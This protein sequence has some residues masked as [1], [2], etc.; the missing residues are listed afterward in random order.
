[1]KDTLQK[2]HNYR[3]SFIESLIQKFKLT[4]I[5][6]SINKGV[7]HLDYISESIKLYGYTSKDFKKDKNF[8]KTIFFQEDYS[9]LMDRYRNAIK[10]QE[11][12]FQSE[13]RIW[14][15]DRKLF[16][17]R[18]LTYLDYNSKGELIR[19]ESIWMDITKE[20]IKQFEIEDLTRMNQNILE[21]MNDAIAITNSDN[22]FTYVNPAFL[23][24][25][26][27][28]NKCFINKNLLT[29]IT[30]EYRNQL[31]TF[32]KQEGKIIKKS[33]ETKI[34]TS[35]NIELDADVSLQKLYNRNGDYLGVLMVI[36]DI[37]ELKKAEND[38]LRTQTRYWSLF[39]SANEAFFV[40]KDDKIEE[41]NKKAEELFQYD[42][43]K[44]IGMYFADLSN[45]EGI[46]DDIFRRKF[47]QIFKNLKY[48]EE[49]EFQYTY[50]K[51]SGKTFEAN[52]KLSHIQNLDESYIFAI[53]DDNSFQRNLQI[54]LAEERNL[55]QT[56]LSN[57]QEAL[58]S[59]NAE[60]KILLFNRMAEKLTGW[61]VKDA[62]G[63]NLNEVL[64]CFHF[65][66]SIL[67][68]NLFN[69]IQEKLIGSKS[70]FYEDRMIILT[71]SNFIRKVS[72]HCSIMTQYKK[73][74]Q[75]FVIVFRDI[76]IEEKIR[77][78]A[79]KSQKMES[80][81]LLAGGI[82]HDFNN[83]L[84]SILGN[85]SIAKL[86]IGSKN[87]EM[88]QLLEETEN[89]IHRA[90]RLTKQLLTFSKGGAPIK[91]ITSL[92]EVIEEN[93]KFALRG[94]KIKLF[95]QIAPDLWNVEV[96]EGQ[97]G[98]CIHNILINALQA[99]PDGGNIIVEARNIKE[100]EK[101]P[102][103]PANQKFIVISIM[104]Q[105]CGIHPEIQA[106]IFDPYF[107]TK[108]NGTGLGL[109]IVYSIISNHNGFITL[110]S[111]VGEGTIFYLYLPAVE[112]SVSAEPKKKKALQRR[113]GNILIMDDDQN[114]RN[115]FEKMLKRLGFKADFTKE[116]RELI[117]FYKD[118]LS[119]NKT[120]DYLILDLTI[121]GGMGGKETAEKILQ[122][123][124][125]QKIIV[126]SGYST[127]PVMANY[128]S[129]G[130]IARLEKPFNIYTLNKIFENFN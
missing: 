3:N 96:D 118:Q 116:G 43:E 78:E 107:T 72:F 101:I 94:S 10:N 48:G 14:S 21:L 35:K 85:I 55:L 91:K 39:E 51:N 82:A 56:T 6:F 71:K 50:C 2:S 114:I 97:I 86:E 99:M 127:D 109:A 87:E 59:L 73:K 23:R 105:G 89:A 66:N 27:E 34:V 38:L 126:T 47:H 7:Y 13:Y 19:N 108:E 63:K 11:K 83:I 68:L 20:K 67:S 32:L 31:Y 125:R 110:D 112:K 70:T 128:K 49:I 15:K 52:T 54:A 5:V 16:W 122:L 17:I 123:N 90:N 42:K 98:Q 46:S 124:P 92:K 88:Q 9:F 58:I 64:K 79:F 45:N 113:S 8:M 37:S 1:M 36:H 12:F 69:E 111:K 75:G 104:D 62:L 22:K 41:C 44:L 130:F 120:Y 80:I 76:S 26:G 33:W 119:K 93:A 129:Y 102:I 84:T 28:D 24:L 115:I 30:S 40:I 95:I 77:E 74:I 25:L 53:L 61:K 29:I 81:G 60:G 103:I 121:P 106:K 117:S 65:E 4:L 57:I 100:S 18:D